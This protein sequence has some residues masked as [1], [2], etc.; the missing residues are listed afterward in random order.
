[1]TDLVLAIL[2]I[3][4]VSIALAIDITWLVGFLRNWSGR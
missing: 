3:G 2:V 4:V 1:M